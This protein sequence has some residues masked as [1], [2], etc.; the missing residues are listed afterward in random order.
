LAN[1]QLFDGKVLAPGKIAIIGTGLIGGSIAASFRRVFSGTWI[2]GYS[3]ANDANVA[4][5]LGLL[6]EACITVEACVADADIVFLACPVGAMPAMFE[7]LALHGAKFRWLTDCGSTKR[8]VIAAARVHLGPVFDRYLPG[9]P[10]AGSERHGPAGASAHLFVKRNWLL[11]PQSPAQERVAE[12]I[13]PVLEALGS[14]VKWVDALSHDELFAEISHFPHWMVF[15]AC[16]GIAEGPHGAAAMTQSG[17]GL[18]DTTRIGASSAALWADIFI[19][20]RE[21][22]EASLD[23]FDLALKQ[24]RTLLETGDRASLTA[25]I[26]RASTWRKLVT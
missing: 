16:L 25:M 6:D 9:H 12:Q 8:S 17:A 15:A 3:Q 20:N 5:Q 11:C 4:L 23:R 7:E 13:A 19:D 2:R 24:M 22:L 1:P 10:I 21:P 14:Q 26:D 18:K